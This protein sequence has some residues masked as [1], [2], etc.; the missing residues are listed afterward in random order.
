MKAKTVGWVVVGLL[1]WPGCV[2]TLNPVYRSQDLVFEPAVLGVWTQ[3]DV[4]SKWEISQRDA[5]SYSVLYTDE[6][7]QQGR[8]IACLANVRGTRFLDLFPEETST[9][10]NG[11]YQM[12]LLPIHTIYLVRSTHPKLELAALDGEWLSKYLTEHP[13][14]VPHAAVKGGQLITASTEKLQDF[15][16]QHQSEFTG[17]FELVRSGGSK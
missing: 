7:G 4:K 6:G 9:D 8:F 11:L 14:A 17:A 1:L 10:A 5:K 13:D 2:P 12:H 3:P 15:L 16:V